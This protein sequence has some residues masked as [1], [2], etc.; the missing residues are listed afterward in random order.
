MLATLLS[1]RRL[2]RVTL[3]LRQPNSTG[4]AHP[5]PRSATTTVV[6]T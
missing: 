2:Y 4:P 6:Y 5:A 1:V 3:A